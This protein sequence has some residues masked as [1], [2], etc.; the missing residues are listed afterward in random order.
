MVTR[1]MNKQDHIAMA[2]IVVYAFYLVGGIYLC[3]KHGV[4]RAAGFR[5]LVI[6]ALARLI[7]SSMLLATLSDAT[8]QSLYTGWAVT[9]GVGLGPLIL[10]LVGLL[11]RTFDWINRGGSI[12]L[13]PLV[14][15]LV[16]L[17]MLVAVVLVIVGG[18]L[19]DYTTDGTSVIVHYNTMSKV[20][21]ALMIVVVVI[22]AGQLGLAFIHKDRIPAGETRLLPAV[23]L[24]I[25]FTIVRLIYGCVVILSDTNPSIWVYL[26]TGVIMEFVICLIVEVIGFNLHKI[27]K[28]EQTKQDI[29]GAET[30]SAY[31]T[32]TGPF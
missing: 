6:L 9:N 31:R 26:V 24:A 4:S 23:S 5:F 1:S 21:M 15:R 32:G 16:Q 29:D 28:Y 22:A 12:V 3:V 17:L 30:G 7:G 13:H 10:M 20:G 25:A 18:T 11:S 8:N 27:P 2:E 19:S 14:T